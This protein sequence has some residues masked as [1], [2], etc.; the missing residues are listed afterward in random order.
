MNAARLRLENRVNFVQGDLLAPI[1][2]RFDLLV[3]NLPYI[4]TG[5]YA[6]LP[7][8]IRAFEPGLALDG[9]EDWLAVI[10]RLLGQVESHAARGAVTLLEISEEQG[11]T[12]TELVQQALSRATVNV[13]KDLEG[14]DRVVEIRVGASPG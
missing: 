5:R 3:A 7:R 10:R 14:M 13:H 9:G 11:K 1:T 12:A 8:E 2:D 4:P 6:E